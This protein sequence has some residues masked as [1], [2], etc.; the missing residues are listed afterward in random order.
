MADPR[1]FPLLLTCEHASNAWPARW[2]G[3]VR[4]P[5]RMLDSHRGW[6]PGAL[7]LAR[8][9]ARLTR[10][11][12]LAGRWS[13]LLVELNRSIHHP[14][15]W[16][17]YS[18]SLPAQSREAILSTVYHPF[19]QRAAET[20]RRQVG[21]ARPVLH[22]SIHTF[23]PELNGQVRTADI[24]LL[25]DPGREAEKRFCRR[26]REVLRRGTPH[27]RVRCNYPYRGCGDGHTTALRRQFSG[28]SYLGIELEVNQNRVLSDRSEWAC[29]Q[30][31]LAETLLTVVGRFAREEGF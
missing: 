19:R 15:L 24:G 7:D 1:S 8:M 5:T 13:R 31:T 30:R 3:R 23:A 17:R 26:W 6:D 28:A 16:S 10:A 27:L 18:R 11:P 20:L 12:L 29:L 14:Q 2:V 21:P 22:L 25:Y 4:P 9:C